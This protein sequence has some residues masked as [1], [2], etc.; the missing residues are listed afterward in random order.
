MDGL[1]IRVRW[2]GRCRRRR[3]DCTQDPFVHHE[4]Y[5]V[6]RQR[7]MQRPNTRGHR[8][9]NTEP[10]PSDSEGLTNTSAAAYTTASCSCGM[11]PMKSTVSD[12]K[13]GCKGFQIL[14]QWPITDNCET[15]ICYLRR[16]AANARIT[17]S[18]LFLVLNATRSEW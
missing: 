5:R 2:R 13:L 16:T 15:G 9:K 18:T 6:C 4:R 1:P 12:A 17:P 8:S 3:V 7:Q 14:A 10:R 11:I